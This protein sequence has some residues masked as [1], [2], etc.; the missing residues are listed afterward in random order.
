MAAAR[1]RDSTGAADAMIGR[2]ADLERCRRLLDD[3]CRLV[4]I[5][6]PAGVGKSRLAAEVAAS[7]AGSD[8]RL[9]VV[10]LAPVDSVARVVPAIADAV[11]LTLATDQP[12]V[13]QVAG[14]LA[15]EPTLV[16]LDNAEHLAG[17]GA[18]VEALVARCPSL[19]LVVTSRVAL[20]VTSER[21]VEVAPLGD[22]DA[23]ALLTRA[24]RDAAPGLAGLADADDEALRRICRRLDGLP[25]AIELAATRLRVLSPRELATTLDEGLAVLRSTIGTD[26]GHYGLLAAIEWSYRLLG[27]TDRQLLRALGAISGP[28]TRHTAA[29]LAGLTAD[30]VIDALE[31]LVAHHLVRVR[32]D[33]GGVR[34]FEQLSAIREFAAGELAAAQED[35]AVRDR[36]ERWALELVEEAADASVRS[37]SHEAFGRVDAEIDN[38]RGVLGWSTVPRSDATGLR[39]IAGLWRYWWARGQLAEGREWCRRVITAYEGPADVHLARALRSSGQLSLQLPLPDEAR[40]YLEQALELFTRHDDELGAADCWVTLGMFVVLDGDIARSEALHRAALEVYRRHGR[41]RDAAVVLSGLANSAHLSGDFAE[42]LDLGQQAIDILREVGDQRSLAVMLGVVGENT[43]ALGDADAAVAMY[44][45]CLALSTEIGDAYGRSQAL[46]RLGRALVCADQPVKAVA[47]LDEALR[48]ADEGGDSI[49]AALAALWLGRSAEL[50]GDVARAGELAADSLERTLAM[51]HTPGAVAT[52]QYLARLAE[53]VGDDSGATQL[54]SASR[55]LLPAADADGFSV[56]TRYLPRAT[57]VT[58]VDDSAGPGAH[59]AWTPEEVLAAARGVVVALGASPRVTIDEAVA[60]RLRLTGR[61]R[62]LLGPLIQRRTD[63]EI[64]AELSISVRTVTTHV[65]AILGKLGVRSRRDVETA[66]RE[67]GLLVG[68]TSS[69][70]QL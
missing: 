60:A 58:H 6:G 4:T 49:A 3:G 59:A 16:V 52:L 42:A 34:R 25:L 21:C 45:E 18:D 55:G 35:H 70:S 63:R 27:P 38:V 7:A 12:I 20:G 33:L 40:A 41:R 37:P 61:E 51:G 31:R 56:E 28:F 66:A 48:V 47:V 26:R 67:L 62:E 30:E 5:I 44:E 69:G 36:A 46:A 53:S 11:G 13:E 29:T 17:C 64:A 15:A 39:L 22:D 14:A 50:A 23:L 43:L 24:A 10:S 68:G 54:V 1:V 9:T 65:S 19:Q 2:D 57:T 32:D 8:R